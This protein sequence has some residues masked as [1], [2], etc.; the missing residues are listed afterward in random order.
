MLCHKYLCLFHEGWVPVYVWCLS[1]RHT[2][3]ISPLGLQYWYSVTL[4]ASEMFFFHFLPLWSF[5]WWMMMKSPRNRKIYNVCL[6]SPSVSFTWSGQ[7]VGHIHPLHTGII[8]YP[9]VI[10]MSLLPHSVAVTV[11]Q[12]TVLFSPKLHWMIPHNYKNAG[13]IT[14]RLIFLPSLFSTRKENSIK[15]KVYITSAWFLFS[16]QFWLKHLWTTKP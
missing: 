9:H 16:V 6:F 7:V 1:I 8:I 10:L 13:W 3:R 12:H 5:G 15:S 14:C 2:W 11:A 4:P